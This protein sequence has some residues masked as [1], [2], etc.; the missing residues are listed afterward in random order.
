MTTTA[1]QTSAVELPL[2]GMGQITLVRKPDIGRAVLGSC[3]GL[4]LHH[5]RRGVGALAHIVLPNSEGRSGLAGKFADTA[6]PKMLEMLAEEGANPAGLVAKMTGGANMFGST[7]PLQIGDAN[8]EAVVE[9]LK[10]LRIPIQGEDVAGSKGRR[11]SYNS[12][13]GEVL[14]EIVG[15]TPRTL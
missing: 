5:Q 3:I 14:V 13:T 11:L 1:S 9:H 15:D 2:T 6:L 4:I 10:Q 8:I 12:A 7:G